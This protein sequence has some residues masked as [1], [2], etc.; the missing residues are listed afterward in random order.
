MCGSRLRETSGGSGPPASDGPTTSALRSEPRAVAE[1]ARQDDPVRPPPATSRVA[2]GIS[3]VLNAPV[4]AAV[5]FL[6]LYWALRPADWVGLAAAL[7]FA[8]VVPL[9]LVVVLAVSRVLPDVFATTL[10]SRRWAFVGAA[11]AY[12][13]GWAALEALRTPGIIAYLM[14]AYGV[15][16]LVFLGMSVRWKPSVHASGVT[17]PATW[18]TLAVGAWGLVFFVVLIPVAWARLR[19]RAHTPTEL[20]AGAALAVGLT[21]LQFELFVR[22]IRAV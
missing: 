8:T 2:L 17:G 1:A 6:A 13:A 22:G 12:F 16:T 14:L 20:V 9:V 19:L 15:N 11:G 18:L 4:L 10:D 5:A 21:W 3:L 7:A